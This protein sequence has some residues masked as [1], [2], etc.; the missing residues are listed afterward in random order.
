MR[1]YIKGISP[2][3]GALSER[4]LPDV[5]FP[6]MLW[7][8]EWL[9]P[10]EDDLTLYTNLLRHASLGIN[11]ASTVSLELL[12]HDKP[13]INLDFDPPGSNLPSALGYHRHIIFDHYH[14]VAE[15]GAVMVAR[16]P[17]DMRAT[18]QRGLSMPEA[19]SS[20]RRQFI[21]D[22]FDQRLD[23]C[24]GQRV[25]EGLLDLATRASTHKAESV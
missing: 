4:N 3:M 5:V 14:P 19:D 22:L 17:D 20:V 2:E 1:T 13:V 15:S 8:P 9:M 25:A 6:P 24:A 21:Q 18:L 10:H 16:S 12:M 23:G 11:A 7:D